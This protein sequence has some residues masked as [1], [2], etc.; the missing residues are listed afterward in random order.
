[1]NFCSLDDCD[2]P[3]LARKLC[4]AHWQ[5]LRAYGD[6]LGGKPIRK[7]PRLK[8]HIVGCSNISVVKGFCDEHEVTSCSMDECGRPHCRDT[9]CRRHH[10]RFSTY[11]DPAAGGPIRNTEHD[12][13]CQMPGCSEKYLSKGLCDAHYAR[14]RVHGD[15]LYQPTFAKDQPC[16]VKGCSNLQIGNGYCGKHYQRVAKHGDPLI[17]LMAEAGKGTL[18]ADGYRIMHRPGH[19][20]ANKHGKISEHR[21]VATEMLGRPLLPGENIHHRNGNRLDNRPENLELWITMQPTGQRAADLV[22]YARTILA[23][24][25]QMVHDG[26]PIVTVQQSLF[27]TEA[28]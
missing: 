19:P 2:R 26:A 16:V 23:R 10:Y 9:Y 13:T 25:G 4:K 27:D 8:C 3:V 24:Y 12:E 11:G 17:L 20:N 7:R 21:L 18:T 22:D 1:M 5:R 14:R 6:P 15:P 28:A